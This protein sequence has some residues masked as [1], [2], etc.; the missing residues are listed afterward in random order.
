M[1]SFYKQ[2]SDSEGNNF[3]FALIAWGSTISGTFF[4]YEALIRL[5]NK[6]LINFWDKIIDALIQEQGSRNNWTPSNQSKTKVISFWIWNLFEKR[7]QWNWNKQEQWLSI[8]KA[9]KV[10]FQPLSTAAH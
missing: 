1:P 5:K 2:V 7:W 3:R 8:N 10:K 4:L 6:F 9:I